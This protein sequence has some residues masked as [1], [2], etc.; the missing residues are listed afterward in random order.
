MFYRNRRS[1]SNAAA[2]ELR[3]RTWCRRAVAQATPGSGVVLRDGV[4]MRASDC[5]VTR[6]AWGHL[7]ATSPRHAARRRSGARVG[8]AG[9]QV[10]RVRAGDFDAR[11]VADAKLAAA[12]DAHD[13]VDLRRVGRRARDRDA[14]PSTSSTSTSIVRPTLRASRAALIRAC[15]A[16]KRARR[17]SRTSCGHRVG[18]RVGRRAVD[19]RVGEAADAVELRFLEEVEQLVRSRLRSRRESRR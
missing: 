14:S 18:Q 6:C 2:V 8:R 10:V 11:E 7:G 3:R 17:S 1:L 15:T 4:A 9:R 19:R 12:F 16:M 5:A 13:A